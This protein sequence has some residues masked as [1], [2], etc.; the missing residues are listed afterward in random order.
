M[1]RK[2]FLGTPGLILLTVLLPVA[3]LVTNS[4][5]AQAPGGGGAEQ[6][7]VPRLERRGSS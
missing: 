1:N 5:L 7:R 4:G 3:M 2:G 6:Q